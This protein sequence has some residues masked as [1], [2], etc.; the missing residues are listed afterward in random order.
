MQKSIKNC[1]LQFLSSRASGLAEKIYSRGVYRIIARFLNLI[2]GHIPVSIAEILVVLSI[3]FALFYIV[4]TIIRMIYRR[5]PAVL[6]LY[7]AVGN[8]LSNA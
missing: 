5:K 2:S 8:Q 7:A 1:F 4:K 3:L 6:W